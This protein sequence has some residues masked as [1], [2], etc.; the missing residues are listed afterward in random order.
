MRTIDRHRAR[1]TLTALTA[2]AILGPAGHLRAQTPDPAAAGGA[3]ASCGYALS[4]TVNNVWR[5]LGGKEGRLGCPTALEGLGAASPQGSGARVAVFGQNGEI[6]LHTSGPRAGQA[7]AVAG[8]CYRLYVQYGAT[9]G[10]LGLPIAEQ[11][12]TPD[13]SRQTFEGGVMRYDRTPDTCEATANSAS[14]PT[15]AAAV[16]ANSLA[17][18]DVFENV[19]TGDRLS[20]GSAGSVAEA[21][22]DGYQ[23]LRGQARVLSR[24]GPGTIRLELYVNEANGFQ[25]TIASPQSERAALA[26]GYRFEAGQGWVWPDPRPGAI[27]LELFR[28][29]ATERTRLTA[30][31]RDEE[32]AA[33]IGYRFVRVEGYAAPP[34]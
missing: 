24:E 6:V 5:D 18:L 8:G 11:E 17:P 12:N 7:F 4:E 34:P 16:P 13:G 30:G 21:L 19:A 29:P 22:A 31:P 3:D 20:L 15:A 26:T 25:E 9:S 28:N 10:W 27:A 14:P 2:A 32:A 1:V 23:R 33:A